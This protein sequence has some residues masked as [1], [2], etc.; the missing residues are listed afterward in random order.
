MLSITVKELL[1]E[2]AELGLD[3]KLISGEGYL[4]NEIITSHIQKPGLLLTEI[5]EELHDRRIQILG[6]A[7]IKYLSSTS[8]EGLRYAVK[9]LE[10]SKLPCMVVTRGLK[11]PDPL[12]NLSE[13]KR[14]PLF[15]TPLSSSIFIEELTKFLDD[16]FAPTT[17]IHGVLVDVL[18]VGI[19]LIGKSGVGKSECALDLITRGNRLVADDVVI[20]KRRGRVISG[21][22]SDVI[23]YHMEVRG[24]GIINVK[25]LF[26]ITATRHMKQLDVVVELI[27]WESEQADSYE[28]L[29]FDERTYD[30]LGVNFPYLT[31]P[32]SPGRNVA[33]IV[34]VAARNQIIKLMGHNSALEFQRQMEQAMGG[35]HVSLREKP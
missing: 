13:E 29:G 33:A 3:L 6:G 25:E 15:I 5:P 18:G 8:S 10:R 12:V 28:R 20:F 22:S 11:V 35:C 17:T 1:E 23:K 30:I 14:F 19:L 7:E 34:E 9:K 21:R 32:V 4:S 31:I 24:L 16:K 27:H 26:G 2:G